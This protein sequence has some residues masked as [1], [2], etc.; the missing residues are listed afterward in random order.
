M[1][2]LALLEKFP[3][4]TCVFFIHGYFI[5]KEDLWKKT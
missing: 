5:S 4:F 1:D 3:Q 2:L